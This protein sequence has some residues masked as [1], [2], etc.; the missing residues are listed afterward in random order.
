MNVLFVCTG[1]ICRSPLA[2]GILRDKYQQYHLQ[3]V[4][5]SC[6]FEAFHVGDSPDNRAQTVARKHFIDISGHRSRLFKV[7]D[8]DRFDK[9]YVMDSTHYHHVM[10]NARNDADRQK[11]D[12][13]MNV[14]LPGSNTPVRDPWYDD[15]VAFENVF[16]QL[17]PACEEIALSVKSQNP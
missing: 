3:G 2:E 7:H 13:I 4:I 16:A 12:Y 17:D 10:R 9:I 5:D 8:F 1:N 14:L 11:V 15:L 6:G